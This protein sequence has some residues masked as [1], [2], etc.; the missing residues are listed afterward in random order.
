MKPDYNNYVENFLLSLIIGLIEGIKSG[1]ISID[2][3]EI[4]LF[5]PGKLNWIK[6]LKLDKTLY[7]LIHMGTELEDIKSLMPERLDSKLLEMLESA[8]KILRKKPPIIFDTSKLDQQLLMKKT[9]K[10]KLC[11]YT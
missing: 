8:K 7:N 6:E 5:T 4:L 3:A 2:E 1:V 9:L 10:K 11:Q